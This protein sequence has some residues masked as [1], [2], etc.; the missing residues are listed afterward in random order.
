MMQGIDR[1]EFIRQSA[2]TAAV[3]GITA[4]ASDSLLAAPRQVFKISLAQ[5]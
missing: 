4:L 3:T 5:W 1:R 2:Q